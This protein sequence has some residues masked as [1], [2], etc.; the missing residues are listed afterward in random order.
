MSVSTQAR[1]NSASPDARFSGFRGIDIVSGRGEFV[2]DADGRRYLDAT[3]MYGVASIGH[4][5]QEVARA[6]ADQASRLVSCF[7][8]YGHPLRDELCARLTDLLTPLERVHLCS[9]GSEAVETAIKLARAATGRPNVVALRGGF[10]GRTLG[11]LSATERTSHRSGFGP[12]IPGFHHVDRGDLE[13]LDA[14]LTE[15][16]ALLLLEVVQGEGGVQA[17]SG[18][19]LRGAQALCRARGVLFAVD[20]VQTGFGRSGH[21][22]AYQGHGLDPDLVCLAKALGGGLPI[23]ATVMR[24]ELAS[25]PV[26]AHGSTFGGNPLCCAA[27]LATLDVIVSERLVERSARVGQWSLEVLRDQLGGLRSVREVRGHGLM[28]AIDLRLRSAPV[29]RRLQ[30]M[31]YLCLGAGPTTLRLLPPLVTRRSSLASLAG[32][33]REV[34]SDA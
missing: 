18:E 3:S 28:F 19:F 17:L 15:D 24:A 9:S 6:V 30:E 20:E 25:L 31:G 32:A 21:W 33:L 27:A 29:Q 4:A 2:W 5:R 11:A 26:G 1:A 16:T 34:L 14:A 10:H 7:G 8:S 12:L 23:G 13:E 22:F